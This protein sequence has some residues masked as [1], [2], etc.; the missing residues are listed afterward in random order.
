MDVNY[1]QSQQDIPA[2]TTLALTTPA[3]AEI[4][5]I[6]VN[7]TKTSK[8]LLEALSDVSTAVDLYTEDFRTFEIG[9]RVKNPGCLVAGKSYNLYLDVTP[10]GCAEN[11]A[12]TAVRVTVKV[13]K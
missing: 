7:Q 13:A 9:I 5:S 3:S 4:G 10:A 2:Y 1:Y 6:S 12:P 8:E 11:V